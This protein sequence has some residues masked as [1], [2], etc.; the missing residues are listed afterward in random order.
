ME[1]Q[2][3]NM[4]AAFAGDKEYRNIRQRVTKIAGYR[5]YK[6]IAAV[7]TVTAAMLFSA[8]FMFGIKKVSYDRNI[9]D[10]HVLIYGYENGDVTYINNSD[11]LY[12]MISYD[13][14]YVYVDGEAFDRFVHENNVDGDI[15]IVFGGFQKLPGI[16]G[17]GHSCLYENDGEEKAVQIPYDN[18]IDEWLIKLYRML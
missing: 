5:P 18:Y 7:G 12:R 15:Y 11:E 16:G 1:S 8:G 14:S 13:G 2:D 9:E 3:F 17:F 4:Y 6:K 10:V